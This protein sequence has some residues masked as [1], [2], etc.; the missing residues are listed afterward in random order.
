MNALPIVVIVL[1]VGCDECAA[2]CCN[3]F[4]GVDLAMCAS[5]LF[6]RG[7]DLCVV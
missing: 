5:E 3:C 2:D 1:L 7:C 6:C 4:V